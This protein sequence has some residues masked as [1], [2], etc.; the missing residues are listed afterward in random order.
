MRGLARRLDV[1]AAIYWGKIKPST[2]AEAS[3]AAAS[4]DPRATAALADPAAGA[5][6][7]RKTGADLNTP[8]KEPDFVKEMEA[9]DLEKVIAKKKRELAAKQA[10]GPAPSKNSRQKKRLK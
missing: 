7:E 4:A 3:S 6:T 10:Q 8:F 5:A 9:S 1:P 2:S